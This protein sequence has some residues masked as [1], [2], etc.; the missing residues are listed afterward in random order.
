[1]E[2]KEMN[3][4]A[5]RLTQAM[6]NSGVTQT[7]LS[8]KVGVSQ[9]AIQKLVSGKSKTSKKIFEI[10]SY[11][12]VDPVWLTSG[13]IPKRISAWGDDTPMEGD[14]VN[15]PYYREVE[16][17]AGSGPRKIEFNTGR[18][19]RFSRR[20]LA[21]LSIKPE[22]AACVTVSGNSM[23]PVMPDGSTVG[24]DTGNTSIIDGDIYA[25]GQHNYLR[26]KMVYRIPWGGLRLQSFNNADWPD[27]HHDNID[28]IMILG[29]VFWYSALI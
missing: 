8:N 5:T 22:N 27:E 20:T 21:R 28:D 9:T 1:M 2:C 11:L 13:Q 25:I 14:D 10:A 26:V 29:R 19:L 7:E 16:L 23:E 17:A 4:L 3:T 15:L 18:T 24:I 12:G 6:I